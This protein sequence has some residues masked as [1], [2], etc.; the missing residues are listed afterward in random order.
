MHIGGSLVM[1]DVKFST[2][3]CS[4]VLFDKKGAYS[5]K[6]EELINSSAYFPIQSKGR[7]TA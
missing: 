6:Y 2:I 5:I 7:V 4:E 1:H 3:S